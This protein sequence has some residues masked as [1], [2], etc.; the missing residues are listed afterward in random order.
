MLEDIAAYLVD[1]GHGVTGTSLFMGRLPDTPTAAIALYESP[2]SRPPAFTH[3]SPQPAE[4]FPRLQVLVRDAA[5]PLA[6][7]RAEA[8]YTALSAVVNATLGSGAYKRIRPL[9]EP[10]PLAPD[11][12]GR[13][14]IACNYEITR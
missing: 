3:D 10:F 9:Q 6:R 12:S 14:V 8:I 5:Y 4:R 13:V 2:A 11:E 1:E 7:T